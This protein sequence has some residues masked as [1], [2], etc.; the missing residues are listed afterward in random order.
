VP[1]GGSFDRVGEVVQQVPPVG[2][3]DGERGAAG[4]TLGIAAA[5]VPANHLNAM[6]GIQP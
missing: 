5:P 4:G 2:D 3:L 1:R 6:V